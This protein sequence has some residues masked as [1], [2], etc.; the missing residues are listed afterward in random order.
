KP[1]A[2]RHLRCAPGTRPQAYPQALWMIRRTRIAFGRHFRSSYETAFFKNEERRKRRIL[3]RRGAE[4]TP[5]CPAR[6]RCTTA[7]GNGGRGLK[8]Q[9]ISTEQ[10]AR[11]VHHRSGRL[12]DL[13]D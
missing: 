8:C 10:R 7:C 3:I 11:A 1:F 5:L 13:A 12:A 9:R 4:P 6:P 2:I